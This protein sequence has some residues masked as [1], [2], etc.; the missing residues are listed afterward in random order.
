M[1]GAKP[2]KTVISTPS[3]QYDLSTVSTEDTDDLGSSEVLDLTNTVGVTELDTN[4]A[5][6]KTLLGELDDQLGNFLGAGLEPAGSTAAVREGGS[7]NTLTTVD[8][9][10]MTDGKGEGYPGVCMRPILDENF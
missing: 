5:G 4:L 8:M 2:T 3:I 10:S 6:R 1:L 9:I 7:R